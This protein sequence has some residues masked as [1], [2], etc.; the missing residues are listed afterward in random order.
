MVPGATAPVALYVSQGLINWCAIRDA[1]DIGGIQWLAE[2]DKNDPPTKSSYVFPEWQKVEVDRTADELR[3]W[4]KSQSIARAL[5]LESL[6]ER[7]ASKKPATGKKRPAKKERGRPSQKEADKDIADEFKQG[8]LAG[9]W[10]TIAEFA[11][12]KRRNRSTISK[13]ITRWSKSVK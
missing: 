10:D 6:A 9:E 8:K 13:A 7:L 5:I 3:A 11:R 4:Y 2:F 12:Y 1:L